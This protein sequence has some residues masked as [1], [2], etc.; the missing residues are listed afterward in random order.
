MHSKTQLNKGTIFHYF[1]FPRTK[2]HL[3]E[4]RRVDHWNAM[5]HGFTIHGL[6]KEGLMCFELMRIVHKLESKLQHYGG[7]IDILVGID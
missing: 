3:M 5:I 1:L 7:I 6:A 4:E 2:R